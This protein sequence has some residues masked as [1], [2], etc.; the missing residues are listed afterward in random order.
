M[1]YK[2]EFYYLTQVIDSIY[3]KMINYTEVFVAENPHSCNL[4]KTC[5]DKIF[6]IEKM[7]ID[8]CFLKTILLFEKIVKK[9]K[10]IHVKKEV[11]ELDIGSRIKNRKS[12]QLKLYRYHAKEGRGKYPIN[13][14]L[15]DLLGY[16][17]II[18]SNN[19]LE[20]ISKGIQFYVKN[21]YD[22][23]KVKIQ[24]ASK[25]GYKA[26]HIYFKISNQC[27][28][29]ELQI[30]LSSDRVSNEKSHKKYKQEYLDWK[31]YEN[32]S[33]NYIWGDMDVL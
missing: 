1:K 24:N 31:E 17:L 8:A 5:I 15:N 3:N 33:S 30:W 13:K 22:L 23:I 19:T 11:F 26:L 27:F 21:N 32:V 10:E 4:K 14:C 2:E 16:R 7:E 20:D 25:Q 29:C 18:H 6:D 28:P 12:I 9:D